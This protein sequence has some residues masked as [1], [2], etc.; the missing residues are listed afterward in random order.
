MSMNRAVLASVLACAGV[1][2]AASQIAPVAETQ[3]TGATAIQPRLGAFLFEIT[4]LADPRGA[5]YDAAGRL[6][7]ADSGHDRVAVFDANGK[8]ERAIGRRGSGRGDLLRPQGVALADDGTVFVADTG[9]DRIQ[10]FNAAGEPISVW[11]ARGSRDGE[12]CDPVALALHGERVYVVD[13][14]NHRVQALGRDG[15]FIRTMGSDTS[16]VDRRLNHP[17]DVAIDS[18]GG[19]YVAA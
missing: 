15:R 2:S 13:A 16:D 17:S 18:T 4:G 8:L 5:A 7:V 10:Q 3:Q 6:F 12:F 9:N 1:M 19:V 11:G 14:G